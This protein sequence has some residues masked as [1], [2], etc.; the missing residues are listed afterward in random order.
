MYTTIDGVAKI[1]LR[2]YP[3]VDIDIA[4]VL[5]DRLYNAVLETISADVTGVLEQL[6]ELDNETAVH[7]ALI[8]TVAKFQGDHIAVALRVGI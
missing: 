8:N 5:S 2:H 4:H 3:H 7:R 6:A 1:L